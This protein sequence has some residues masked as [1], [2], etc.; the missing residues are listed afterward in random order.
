MPMMTIKVTAAATTKEQQPKQHAGLTG[1]G[2]IMKSAQIHKY[3]NTHTQLSTLTQTTK[4][5][6]IC[7]VS[8]TYIQKM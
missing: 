8:S 7:Q 2:K 1:T 6:I 4:I 3:T 5:I